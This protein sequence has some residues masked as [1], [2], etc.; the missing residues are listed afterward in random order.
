METP[1]ENLFSALLKLSAESKRPFILVGGN[2]IN[3]H[4]YLRTT[5]D[6]DVAV[7]DDDAAFWRES[8]E[9]MGYQMFFGTDAFQ[10]YKGEATTSLMPVDLI[11]LTNQTF[12]KMLHEARELPVGAVALPVASPLHLIAMKLHALKQPHRAADGKDFLDIIGLIRAKQIDVQSPDFQSIIS[13][14]AD[15]VT[16]EKLLRSLAEP[17]G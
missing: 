1:Q 15:A 7:T 11:F 13:K 16:R 5:Y 2:A 6:V 9:A 17:D 12:T 4:G 10:R 3:A 14:H 8:L